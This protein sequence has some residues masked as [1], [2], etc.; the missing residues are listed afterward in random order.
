MVPK[1][2]VALLH[3]DLEPSPVISTGPGLPALSDF[4]SYPSLASARIGRPAIVIAYDSEWFHEGGDGSS[5]REILSW[6]FAVIKGEF[7]HEFVFLRKTGKHKLSLELAV[8]RI[9]DFLQVKPTDVRKVRRYASLGDIDPASG[10]RTENW[11]RT[12]QEA[13]EA[14]RSLY[15]DRKRVKTRRDWSQVASIPVV[16]LCHSGKVDISALDQGRKGCRDILKCCTEVQ[17]GLISLQPA[18][19]YV[20]SLSPKYNRDSNFFPHAYPVS[21]R[22][23]DTMCHAP[24]GMKSLKA[25]GEVVGWRKVELGE[26]V[27]SRMDQLLMDDP[28]KYFEY[29][30]NDSVVTLLYAS[31]LYGYNRQ[32]PVTV[33][34]AAAGI[35]KGIMKGYLGA[36]TEKEY[37]LLYRGLRTVGHGLVPR[38]DRPG[39][40][41]STSKEPVS[42]E[43]NMVQ[44]YASEAYHG[45]YNSCSKVGYFPEKTFDYDLQNA[46]P[47]AMCLVPDVD[48]MNPIRSEIKGRELALDDFSSPITQTY[49]PLSMMVAYIR[50]EFPESVRYPCI[51]VNVDGIPVFP[52][53]SHG[54]DGV[55]ACGPEISLALRLG[56]KVF[57]K[58]GF[59]VRTLDAPDASGPSRSLRKAVKQLV[60]DRNRAKAEHGKKSLEELILKT[61][62]N[63]GY[64]KIAQDVIQKE[65]WTASSGQMVDIGP[66]AVTNPM[67]ACMITSIVRAVLLAA[68]DQCE[69]GGYMTCSVTTDGFISN[70]PEAFLKSLD[71]YGLRKCVEQARLFLT[72]GKS[73]ELWEAKHEQDDLVNFTTRG[74]VSL[75]MHGVCAHNSTKSGFAADSY[76]DRLWLMK[77][78]L[79]RTGTVDYVDSKWT[80]FR[81]LVEGAPFEVRDVTRHIRM[82]FDMKR[83]PDRQS[84]L[85]HFVELDGEKYEIANFSTAPFEDVAEFRE[86]R[87][88][89]DA[90]SCLRTMADW[91]L[92]WFKAAAK[93]TKAKVRDMKWSVLFSC[94][95][96]HR[97]GAWTI[98]KLDEL[99]GKARCNWL[100]SHNTSGKLF[101]ANDWKKAG[102][103][104]RQDCMLSK[105]LLMEK[106]EELISD[107]HPSIL[108]A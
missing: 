5:P 18:M 65:T 58:R 82:D 21:L 30:S 10:R 1:A 69:S 77:S 101:E 38:P 72:D 27:I 35:M 106:L 78:V 42:D 60:A 74:N 55:Y 39:Y 100:N 53:T 68:Q 88:R 29:A 31:S 51:P 92:F 34:S 62:V 37:E 66:S 76:E 4:E 26:G 54:L 7:L 56:A 99:K 94:V 14:S 2:P 45:G 73:A 20:N 24:A 46:Y 108:A 80:G 23:A 43:A 15:D 33:T 75:S 95:M 86:Y 19:L 9:L 63:S 3:R 103:K 17:G 84:F 81:E 79:S 11:F 36:R 107:S 93:S 102:L 91:D 57:C 28:R 12:R 98:P 22:V 41:A 89:K 59:F 13:V 85:K 97:A 40:T 64:G 71:L 16:L 25:L 61:M 8:G 87:Q 50:F 67:S 104:G 70:M 96:G 47:T 52:R 105:D 90:V 6:Q 48:W 49:D 32:I 83:K 44:Y